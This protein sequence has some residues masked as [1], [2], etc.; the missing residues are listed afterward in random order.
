MSIHVCIIH[1]DRHHFMITLHWSLKFIFTDLCLSVLNLQVDVVSGVSV[2]LLRAPHGVHVLVVVCPVVVRAGG[3]VVTVR[4]AVTVSAPEKGKTVMVR[5]NEKTFTSEALIWAGLT[6]IL[7]CPCP[8]PCSCRPC[9]WW[10]RACLG[11]WTSPTA[12]CSS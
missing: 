4:E 9:S 10:R 2:C 12:A 1:T 8:R 6:C 11:T 5:M 7:S 3:P